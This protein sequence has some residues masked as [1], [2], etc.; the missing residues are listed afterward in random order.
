[1]VQDPTQLEHRPEGAGPR[2]GDPRDPRDDLLQLVDGIGDYAIFLLDPAGQVAT[3]NAGAQRITGYDA[4]EILG[5]ACAVFYTPEQVAT[6]RPTQDLLVAAEMGRFDG[7]GWRVRKDGRRFWASVTIIA[8]R[9]R[10]GSLRG[11]GKI[12]HD[13]TERYLDEATTSMS[14]SLDYATTMGRLAEL[15]VPALADWCLVDVLEG[16]ELKNL[17][18]AHADPAQTAMA[19]E[20]QRK[21]G[22]NLGSQRGAATVV[23]SG[24]GRLFPQISDDML[25][26][27][28][29]NPEML[30][31]LR[32]LGLCSAMLVPIRA[33]GRTLGAI[34][35]LS[36]ESG[37]RYDRPDL[38][39]AEELGRR[40]G[41][42]IQN[43]RAYREARDAIRLREEFLSVAGHELRTPL[44]A[45][46]LQ[47]QSLRGAFQNG[48]VVQNLPRWLERA[49]RAC[50]H[51]VR[52][53]RLVDELLDVSRITSGRIVL[54]CETFDLAE[55]AAEV[56]ERHGPDIA[57]A[58]SRV[59]FEHGGKTVGSWDRAR[60]GQIVTNLL[61]NAIKYG[62]GK[63]IRVS[64]TGAENGVSI[65]V[66][67]QG[68]GIR[69]EDQG[70]VFER[71]ERAVSDRHYGGFGLGLWIVRELAEAHGGSVHFES[72]QG[73]GSTFTVEM[74]YEG[75][76]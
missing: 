63:P 50:D 49:G 32:S 62:D 71:F 17:A 25:V 40:A 34:T 47:L 26:A 22:P 54:H 20:L 52:L 42:A 43:A 64:V 33:H 36:A 61:D 66:C 74:P 69:P 1:V 76:G 45:L 8:Q 13:M 6:G 14:E 27:S 60:I 30:A 3:W 48:V 9:S 44:T 65:V 24:S 35:L 57:H 73:R 10:D 5:R 39:L 2:G 46:L 75:N 11:F 70:R 28:S 15:L 67:D 7:E 19:R 55:L 37:R 41:I 29:L 68:I 53:G 4:E 59:D 58:G 18:L 72:R 56:V 38:A 31:S 12:T 51:A 16:G 23:R 21:Y